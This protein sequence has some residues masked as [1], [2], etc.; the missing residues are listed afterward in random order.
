L[1]QINQDVLYT[2]LNGMGVPLSQFV[3]EDG[4][5]A[6]MKG[7]V[8]PWFELKDSNIMQQTDLQR[9]YQKPINTHAGVTIPPASDSLST[10]IDTNGYNEIAVNLK[11]DNGTAQSGIVLLWSTDGS[12]ATIT[13][14][15]SLGTG[16]A[17]WSNSRS[18]LTQTK[19]RWVQV[20][21]R[22]V[23][24]AAPHTIT[25]NTYLKV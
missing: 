25:T 14:A 21:A 24:A 7:N 3:K 13:G 1:A 20:L 12:N 23:D 18:V 2:I 6:L 11:N 15:E 16:G 5:P 8:A 10:W 22:N 4:T 17:A 19:A 9:R